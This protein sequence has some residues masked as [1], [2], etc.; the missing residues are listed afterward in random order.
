VAAPAA[1]ELPA[2]AIGAQR[3]HPLRRKA[4]LVAAGAGA[5]VVGLVTGL[6]HPVRH[7]GAPAV[8]TARAAELHARAIQQTR[9]AGKLEW[10]TV[11]N[12]KTY[13]AELRRGSTTVYSVVTR[14]SKLTP[15]LDLALEPGTYRWT[16]TPLRNQG[17]ARPVVEV[18]FVVNPS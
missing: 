15:P 17:E 11:P 3:V 7:H 4:A 2:V 13:R 1:A 6:D 8:T 14:S 9:D 16:V 18:S 5:V 10:P 12:V